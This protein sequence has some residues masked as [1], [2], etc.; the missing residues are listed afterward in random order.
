VGMCP[1]ALGTDGE[2]LRGLIA[3]G[4]GRGANGNCT[5]GIVASPASAGCLKDGIAGVRGCSTSLT[6]SVL[7]LAWPLSEALVRW[8]GSGESP[9]DEPA[10]RRGCHAPGARP[11]VSVMSV[12]NVDMCLFCVSATGL[13]LAEGRALRCESFRVGIV[14]SLV[15]ARHSIGHGHSPGLST[16]FLWDRRRGLT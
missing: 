3:H 4:D 16:L 11:G 9:A 7:C 5:G 6:G 8:D 1:A 14:M 13:A 12:V 2:G 15:R 10:W